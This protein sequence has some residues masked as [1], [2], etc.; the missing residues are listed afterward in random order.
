[1]E[2]EN[3][4]MTARVTGRVQ[5]VGYRF[6]VQRRANAAQLR[7]YVRNLEDGSVEVVGVGGREPLM[8]LLS[9]LSEGPPGSTVEGVEDRL[10]EADVDYPGF[11]IRY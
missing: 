11:N 4:K 2:E 7:G 10:E 1:M 6:F 3:L 5:G 9:D 8:L